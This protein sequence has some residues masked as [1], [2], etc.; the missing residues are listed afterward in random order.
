MIEPGLVTAP[1]SARTLTLTRLA[2]WV[3]VTAVAVG[4]IVRVRRPTQPAL[5]G[6]GKPPGYENPTTTGV[7]APRTLIPVPTFSD[8]YLTTRP[9]IGV[10]LP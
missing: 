5:A 1:S 10:G 2:L 8:P 7:I 4:V 9:P 6:A 3:A